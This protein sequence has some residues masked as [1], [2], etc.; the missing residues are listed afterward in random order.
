MTEE[1]AK[2]LA[3][4][5]S[6][7]FWKGIIEQLILMKDQSHKIVTNIKENIKEKGKLDGN[8]EYGFI[9]AVGC[10]EEVMNGYIEELKKGWNI[11]NDRKE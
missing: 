7:E 3:K 2:E 6:K 8:A 9:L 1:Q 4:N 5:V 10:F 11:E